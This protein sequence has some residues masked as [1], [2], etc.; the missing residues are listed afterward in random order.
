[1]ETK[2]NCVFFCVAVVFRLLF[3]TIRQL[4]AELV[5]MYIPEHKRFSKIASVSAS[6]GYQGKVL[7]VFSS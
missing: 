2:N 3:C 1:M 7:F 6:R 5:P 4:A